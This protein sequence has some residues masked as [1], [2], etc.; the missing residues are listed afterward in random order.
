MGQW[1]N[2]AKP[3]TVRQRRVALNVVEAKAEGR[4]R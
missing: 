3:Q 4:W 1:L 2:G